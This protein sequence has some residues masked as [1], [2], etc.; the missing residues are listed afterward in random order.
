MYYAYVIKSL[1]D[2]SLYKGHCENIELRMT[3][4]N[5]GSTR[6]IANK[7]PFEL[8]YF[9]EFKAREDA[10]KREKYFKNAAGRKFIKQKLS[11]T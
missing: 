2:H 6:S 3:Q 8:V 11:L 4:H 5:N 1:K 7:I 10:I 9:E